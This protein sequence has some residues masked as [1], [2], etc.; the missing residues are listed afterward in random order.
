MK[1]L[2]TYIAKQLFIG[3]V[4]VALGLTGIIWLSQSLRMIDWI[5]NK[6]ISIRLFVE[7]TLLVLPNFVAIITP[8]AFFIVLLFTYN[9]LLADRELVVMKSLGMT[10]WQLAKP[11]LY[12][13]CILVI[14]GYLLTLWI[15]PDS[16]TRFKEL[17]FKIRND[18]A[19]VAIQEGTFNHLPNN[20]TAYVRVF[21]PSMELSGVFI[22]DVRDPSKRVV[23][24]AQKGF[25]IPGNS[26]AS[27]V[28]YNG[29]RIEYDKEKSDFVSSLSFE[30]YKMVFENE[31]KAK[32]SRTESEG[33]QSLRE[34][35]ML[36]YSDKI[37]MNVYR[38]YKVEAFKRLT[39]PLYA[40]VYLVIG[41]LPF[42]L[43]YYNR[44]GQSG[45]I[46]L[47]VFVV[48]LIQSMALGFENLSNKNLIYLFLMGANIVVPLV[49]CLFLLKRSSFP[50]IKMFFVFVCFCLI[51]ISVFAK[52]QFIGND[53]QD[54]QAPATFEAD[55][56]S[57]DEKKNIVT[58]AGNVIVVQDGTIVTA[59]KIIYNRQANELE[60]L[61]HVV[62]TRPDGVVV[63]SDA[64]KLTD[65]IKEAVSR[66]VEM[67]LSDGSTFIAEEINRSDEGNITNFSR[68]FFTPCDYC[69][70]ETPLWNIWAKGIIHNYKKQEIIYKHALLEMEGIPVFYWPYLSYPDFQVK[71]KTGFL[72]PSFESSSEMGFGVNAPFFWAISDSQD[73][74]LSP[75]IAVAHAPLAQGTYK[76][77]FHRS[78]LSLNFSATQDENGD[79]L[80]HL[81]AQYEYDLT[82]KLRF[83]GNYFRTSND[84][85]FRRYPIDNVDDQAPWIQSDATLDYF[86]NQDYAYARVYAF[87]N[88]RNDVQNSFIP[89]V[90]QFNY[91]YTSLPLYKGIYSFSQLNSAGVYREKGIDS[92]RLSYLQSF[93]MPY[94]APYGV[95]FNSQASVRFDAYSVQTEQDETKNTSRVYPNISVEMRYPFIQRGEKYSQILEPIL[96][97]VWTPN[98]SLND[99]IPNEDSLDYIFDDIT[100]FSKNRYFGY[101]RVE[102]GARLNYGLQWTLFGQKSMSVSGLFGQ[103]YRFRDNAYLL[104]NSGLEDKF[105]AYVGRFEINLSDVS[106]N[107]RFR[108]NQDTFEQEMSEVSVGVGRDPL[109]IGVSYLYLTT[110]EENLATNT[111]KDREEITLSASSK[112]T[113]A[114]S[115]SGYYQYNLA[116]E[117]GPI[118]GGGAL[119]YENECLI[120]TFSTE[121][122]FTHDRDYEGDTSFFFRVVLKTIGGV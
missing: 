43:G 15:V 50:K 110:P 5:V 77:L 79:D 30:H 70:G 57:Y 42:L 112:L 9:R 49:F 106:L 97:G 71:R 13:G 37:E 68:V 83:V 66:T 105:S 109:R 26:N 47:S 88:L 46:G 87:Q 98:L 53:K 117:G 103:S 10:P 25:F 85:Y 24:V 99:A 59:D 60:A 4:L 118:Q 111:L 102:T 20:V 74:F 51:S 81:K 89:I 44:Q 101:D 76:G 2:N 104:N 96:M 36:Q 40:L 41:L 90:P 115:I 86:G 14:V 18:L 73:L 1:I 61:G 23:L 100:L 119:Q 21:K 69:K 34:L 19:H 29:Q 92:T 82:N 22:H 93:Q 116:K 121:K 64:I 8:I 67:K 11:A 38:E 27:V 54:T 113:R 62:I 48:I 114:W 12:L 65:K 33:E 6:G 35:L 91:Q 56:F 39:Q 16:I 80:G 122:E 72:T 32:S 3:F 31:N 28:L 17:K 95:V 84:T 58:A 108:I 7:L 63:H 45:L 52:P 55:T 107:Y 94:I 75:T 120:L 78:G